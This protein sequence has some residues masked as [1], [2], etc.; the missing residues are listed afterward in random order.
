[1]KREVDAEISNANWQ[2]KQPHNIPTNEKNER[3][4]HIIKTKRKQQTIGKGPGMSGF[5]TYS[6]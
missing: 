2:T 5:L 6:I 1:M 3:D 4:E